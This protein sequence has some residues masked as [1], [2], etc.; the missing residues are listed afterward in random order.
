MELTSKLSERVAIPLKKVEKV[1]TLFD[2]GATIPFIARYRKEVTGSLD[3]VQISNIQNEYKRLQE[4]LKRKESILASIKE[5]GGLDDRL[6]GLIQDCWDEIILEDRYL[7]F[8]RK[9]KTKASAA[10]D[11]GTLQKQKREI[12]KQAKSTLN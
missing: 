10:R 12:Q 5:Q 11:N 9:V 6:K 4:F 2:E 8:K 7:P 3:E 1:I